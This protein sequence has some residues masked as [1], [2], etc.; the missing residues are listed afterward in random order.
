M[1]T[2]HNVQ[3]VQAASREVLAAVA[4]AV[5]CFGL[6]LPYV[7]AGLSAAAMAFVGS[8]LAGLAFI[9]AAGLVLTA[10]E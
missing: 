2:L 7:F 6:L 10:E 3:L 8:V 9:A 4:V 1:T 5:L